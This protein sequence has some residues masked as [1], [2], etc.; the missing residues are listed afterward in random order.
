MGLHWLLYV[1]WVVQ[2]P[3]SYNR[4]RRT[5]TERERGKE[6][7]DHCDSI[8]CVG[9]QVAVELDKKIRERRERRD[10]AV[11]EGMLATLGP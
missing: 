11:A 4:D 7:A 8:R 6:R 1:N 3:C 2:N 5:K 9:G 10:S